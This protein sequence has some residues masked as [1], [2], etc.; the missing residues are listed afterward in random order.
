MRKGVSRACDLVIGSNRS[1][2]RAQLRTL[3]STAR[4]QKRRRREER[5]VLNTSGQLPSNLQEFS[6]TLPIGLGNESHESLAALRDD[7][8]PVDEHQVDFQFDDITGNESGQSVPGEV[9]ESE[10][11]MAAVHDVVG[12]PW[13]KYK[14][15]R[16]WQQR[17]ARLQ[18]NWSP[19]VKELV[20]AYLEWKGP[21]TPPSPVDP[22]SSIYDFS[23]PVLDVFGMQETA[24]IRRSED[25]ASAAT[26]LVLHGYM[27][28]S[29]TSPVLAI[30][31]RSL[32][33]YHHIRLRKPSFSVEAF[34]KV[35]CDLYNRPY[36]RRYRHQLANA[37]DAYLIVLREVEKQVHE[38]LGQSSDN[39]RV[40]NACPP[41]GFKLE[42]EAELRYCRMIAIDGNNSLSRVAPLGNRQAGDERHFTSDYFLDPDYVNSYADVTSPPT[43]EATSRSAQANDAVD[44]CTDNW[45]AAAE[46][47][48]KKS[49][50][51]FDETGIFACAC[52]HG[53]IVWIVDMIRSGELFKY[54]LSIVS[55]AVDV[56]GPRLLIGYDIGCKLATTIASSPIGA[57][58][59]ESKSRMCVDAFHGY[60]HNY[61]CQDR[62]HPNVIEGA[63]LEDLSTMERIF[64]ASNQL[65]PVIRYAT[66]YNRRTF[67]DMFF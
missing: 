52:R 35:I 31:L 57:K 60:T 22:P 6:M 50:G 11:F 2:S 41:C 27:P 36:A 14:D 59:E 56:L 63:G 19:L 9:S 18:A 13:Y 8:F 15:G 17:Q 7:S 12:K 61:T 26:A 25:G 4:V 62:N 10:S 3:S 58:F 21:R 54:P 20:A 5:Y 47:M 66:A 64:S 44:G 65:A 42:G 1:G 51:I 39:W 33:L 32:E 34:V 24:T 49:W 37:F 40:L 38:L 48:M 16:T 45:K 23:I 46:D 55:R 30:S 53:M 67:I 28:C 29:P 43:D